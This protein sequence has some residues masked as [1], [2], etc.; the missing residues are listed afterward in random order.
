MSPKSRFGA[1]TYK[2]P[3]RRGSSFRIRYKHLS[4]EEHRPTIS[5]ALAGYAGAA[6][7]YA[8]GVVNPTGMLWL[9][10]ALAPVV[11]T[12]FGGVGSFAGA[13]IGAA[14]L[15]MIQ[16]ACIL[17]LHTYPSSHTVF[18]SWSWGY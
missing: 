4:S 12:I 5:A 15:T 18:Y 6:F 9:E 10:I 1:C 16:E 3:R 7:A 11:M 14:V 17:G 13:L 8:I 2:Y